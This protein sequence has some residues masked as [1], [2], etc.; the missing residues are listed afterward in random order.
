VDFL[1]ALGGAGFIF[2]S[3]CFGAASVFMFRRQVPETANTVFL[4]LAG[5]IMIAA[6]VWSLLIPAIE[7]AGVGGFP[8]WL[9][10]ALGVLLG[11][12]FIRGLDSAIPR[13]RRNT[14]LVNSNRSALLTTAITLHNVPEGMA[15]GLGFAVAAR[16]ADSA[17]LGAAMTLAFGIGVQDFPEGAAV[18]LPLRQ[19]GKSARKSFFWGCMS[20]AVEP[21]AAVLTYFIAGGIVPLMPW[22]LSF[23]AG[24][25][26]YVVVDDLIPEASSGKRKSIGTFGFLLGFI[27]MMALDVAM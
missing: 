24:S 2:F 9:P 16:Q 17:A 26:L 4:G 19:G 13:L 15:V 20:G 18:S 22:L 25:M 3:T 21:V 7:M 14:G 5:G 6:S 12:G 1:W 11:A 23:A 27:L 10:P 8:V